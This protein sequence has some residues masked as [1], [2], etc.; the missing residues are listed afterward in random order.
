M[1]TELP[2][3]GALNSSNLDDVSVEF[4]TVVSLWHLLHNHVHII[5]IDCVCCHCTTF[6]KHKCKIE[7]IT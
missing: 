2:N 1:S 7:N 3:A 4:L 5:T 6:Y